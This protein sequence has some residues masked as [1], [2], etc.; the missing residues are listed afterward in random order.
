MKNL[1]VFQKIVNLLTDEELEEMLNFL[2]GF[3]LSIIQ[4]SRGHISPDG[5]HV[6][7]WGRLQELQGFRIREEQ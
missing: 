4:E 2:T 7:N 1:F 5:F 6:S 3:P